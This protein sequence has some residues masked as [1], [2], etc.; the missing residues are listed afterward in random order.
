MAA[1]SKITIRVSSARGS[2]SIQY[3]TAGRYIS[4]PTVGL[5]NQLLRQPIQPTTSLSAFWLS[6]IALVQA[7]ITAG[8]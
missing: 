6:V 7:D 8:S 2:S 5:D 1:T 4:L 3:R